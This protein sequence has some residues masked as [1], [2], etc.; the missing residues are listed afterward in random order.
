MHTAA[1]K[2]IVKKALKKFFTNLKPDVHRKFK[3][4]LYEQ[5]YQNLKFFSKINSCESQSH[6]QKLDKNSFLGVGTLTFLH[7]LRFLT[8]IA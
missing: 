4:K 2:H 8:K 3:N 1:L 7:K 6:T 5:V